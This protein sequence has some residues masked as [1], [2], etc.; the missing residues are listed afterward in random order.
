MYIFMRSIL[1]IFIFQIF[2]SSSINQD[3]DILYKNKYENYK[4][5][6]KNEIQINEISRLKSEGFFYYTVKNGEVCDYAEKNIY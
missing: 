4:N 1:F 2:L 6:Y 5:K 3:F